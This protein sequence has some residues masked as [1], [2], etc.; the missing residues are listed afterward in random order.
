M[1][2]GHCADPPTYRNHESSTGWTAWSKRRTEA[3]CGGRLRGALKRLPSELSGTRPSVDG[4]RPL[5]ARRQ[6]SA[7][8]GSASYLYRYGLH[9]R[10]FHPAP[11]LLIPRECKRPIHGCCL[12]VMEGGDDAS[13]LAKLVGNHEVMDFMGSS[14][15]RLPRASRKV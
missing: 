3:I 2:L 5:A 6:A 12:K 15:E 14:S 10:R 9:V 4:I 8:G 11:T 13:F 7:R 1:H